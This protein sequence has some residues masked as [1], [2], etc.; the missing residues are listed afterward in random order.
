MV[1]AVSCLVSAGAGRAQEIVIGPYVFPDESPFA[2]TAQYLGDV[3]DRWVPPY[4]F[5]TDERVLVGYQPD[6]GLVNL[7]VM[8]VDGFTVCTPREYVDFGFIDVLAVNGPGPDLVIF[9]ARFSTDD[10]EVAVR[11][12]GGSLT[13]FH[14]YY[15]ADQVA[16]GARGPGASW[17]WG[18]NI[19]LSDY[20]IGPGVEVDL[21]RIAGDCATWPSGWTEADP[22]MAAVLNRPCGCDD[23]I[24]CTWDC[25]SE[26]SCVSVP[27]E[28]G[29]PCSLGVCDGAGACVECLE[30]AHCP[31]ERP[32]CDTAI[33]ACVVC[34]ADAECDDANEC[35]LDACADGLCG[36]TPRPR[37]T[38]CATGYCDGEGHC[39][40][41]VEDGHCDDGSDCTTDLCA[42]GACVSTPVEEGTPCDGGRCD[43]E[44][45][46]IECAD[47]SEC[48]EFRP[49]CAPERRCVECLEDA[50]CVV[51][52][53]CE[54]AACEEGACVATPRERGHACPGGRCDG[55]GRCVQCF[56]DLDCPLDAF[57]DDAGRCA[58]CRTDRDCDDGDLCTRDACDLGMG[59]CVH[60][61]RCFDAGVDGPEPGAPAV[62]CGC[63]AAESSR[64]TAA[65]FFGLLLVWRAL[66]RKGCPER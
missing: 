2:D 35:T 34:L 30:D 20:G 43:G 19:E 32:R 64:S 54:T 29:T 65:V 56:S 18:V 59:A 50:Q 10:Y 49:H 13:G 60:E 45:S 11:P 26:G 28:P 21:L 55:G 12:H 4:F 48:D 9:D 33:Q 38:S 51:A 42:D 44:G 25:G 16:T 36:S 5:G 7:G 17:L 24:E 53:P 6:A 66:R 14:Y 61:P 22:V 1:V 57:C 52:G 62:G 3:L 40:Q 63:R 39:L 58:R 8:D 37:G 41:C 15:A 46:C 31:R 47:D 27:H 23:G